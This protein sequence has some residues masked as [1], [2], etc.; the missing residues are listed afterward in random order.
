MG[1]SS[2]RLRSTCSSVI[3]YAIAT[4]RA[5]RDVTADLQ[6]ALITPKVKHHAAIIEPDKVGALL[7]AIDGYEGPAI[8]CLGASDPQTASPDVDRQKSSR[9]A[10]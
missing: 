3:R 7:R 5:Q 10:S 8:G 6:G 2:R 4:G 1:L 9:K